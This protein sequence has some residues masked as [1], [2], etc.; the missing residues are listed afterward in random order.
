MCAILENCDYGEKEDKSPH[1]LHPQELL[2]PIAASQIRGQSAAST[3]YLMYE[4]NTSTSTTAPTVDIEALR[5]ALFEEKK[6]T[7]EQNVQCLLFQSLVNKAELDARSAKAEHEHKMAALHKKC[8][9]K[10]AMLQ[11][12]LT[13]VLVFLAMYA[14]Y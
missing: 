2:P 1:V 10:L 6:K 5:Q 7:A 14:E 3:S 8:D 13:G 9:A 12:E 4:A 11:A